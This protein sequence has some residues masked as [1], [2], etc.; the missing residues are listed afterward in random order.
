MLYAYGRTY[1]LYAIKVSITNL[2]ILVSIIVGTTS[3]KLTFRKLDFCFSVGYVTSTTQD[4][5]YFYNNYL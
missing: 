5:L 4:S 1:V 2:K 3:Y